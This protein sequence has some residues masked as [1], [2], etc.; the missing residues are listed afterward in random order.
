[1][2]SGVEP[3]RIRVLE[4]ESEP[5]GLCRSAM[6]DGSPLDIGGG[7]FLD[8]RRLHVIRFLFRFMP[9]EE[10][11]TF[12]RVARIRLHGIEVDHPLESNLW[13]LP[14][15]MM[16][17]YQDSIEV[18][19]SSSGLPMPSHFEAWV[20]WKFGERISMDY[21]LPYNRKIWSMSLNELDVGWLHKLPKV[22]H[23]DV[24]QSCRERRSIAELP[25]HGR[26]LYPRHHGYGELWRRMG[27]ALGDRLIIDC[28][29]VKVDAEARTVNG[30]WKAGTIVNT[31]PW[32]AWLDKCEMPPEVVS[33][34][35]G[36]RHIS[37][38]IDYMPEDGGSDAHWIYEPDETIG[39]HRRLLRSNFMPAA[40]GQWTETNVRRS[41]EPKAWRY[42]NEHAYPVATIGLK[43]RMELVESWA[44]GKGILS[45]GRWGRWEHMNS[46]VAVEQAIEAAGRI[47]AGSNR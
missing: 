32:T 19:G 1:M 16:N 13:Q 9:E 25:A 39:F 35:E 14:E 33:A 21:M 44:A 40:K 41:S 38:D 29:V 15:E 6:V 37:I 23:R 30:L 46:D 36:L 11:A 2:D 45:L 24:L 4:K 47:R 18:S 34:M 42:R 5:G 27:H 28:P 31:I 10:W 12:D 22:S 26:F 3:E 17:A 43:S 8:T 7:H 20:E